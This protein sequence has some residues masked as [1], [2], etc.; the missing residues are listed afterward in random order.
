M[1][2]DSRLKDT[3]QRCS[4]AF[5]SRRDDFSSHLPRVPVPV[6]AFRVLPRTHCDVRLLPKPSALFETAAVVR[7]QATHPK[8]LFQL[9]DSRLGFLYLLKHPWII[10]STANGTKRTPTEAY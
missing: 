6:F 5:V 4:F 8:L 3:I 10:A 9:L 1:D 2:R 7:L